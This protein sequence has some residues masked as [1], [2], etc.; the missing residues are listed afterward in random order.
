MK[1][2]SAGKLSVAA[3]SQIPIFCYDF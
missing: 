3:S 2:V 1:A